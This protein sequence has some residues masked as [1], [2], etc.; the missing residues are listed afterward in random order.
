[1]KTSLII[2]GCFVVGMLLPGLLPDASALLHQSTVASEYV[3]YALLFLVGIGIGS[4]PELPNI[5]HSFSP[6]VLVVPA[7]TIIGTIAFSALTIFLLPHRTL[8]DCLA[9]GSGMGYYSLSSVLITQ[10]RTPDA[11]ITIAAELGTIAL[12]AN[13]VR[14]LIT[15]LASPALARLFGPLAPICAGGATTADTTFPIITQ[16]VGSRYAFIA[17]IHG[18]IVDASVP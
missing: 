2:V 17:I 3:L 8:A 9:I 1:M 16:T 5:I 14:E 13:I 7:A 10:L 11:G 6:R 12:I 15:L 4:D 18:I